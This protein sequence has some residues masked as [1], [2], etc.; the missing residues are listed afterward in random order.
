MPPVKVLLVS[1][2]AEARDLLR[3]SVGSIE[4]RLGEPSGL[5]FAGGYLGTLTPTVSDDSTGDGA[6]TVGWSFSMANAALQFLGEGETRTQ[7][8]TVTVDDGARRALVESGRSLLPAG[9]RAV[10]R[11]S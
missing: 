10:N 8:Y 6:G 5:G 11:C 3:I 4:R 1:P 7:S 2:D 9:I